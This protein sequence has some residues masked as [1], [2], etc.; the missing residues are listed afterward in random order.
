MPVRRPVEAEVA[1]LRSRPG[2]DLRRAVRRALGRR[3]EIRPQLAFNSDQH[4]RVCCEADVLV[5]VQVIRDP[6]HPSIGIRDFPD[7][8]GSAGR[9]LRRYHQA[10]RIPKPGYASHM[11]PTLRADLPDLS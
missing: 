6:A 3:P 11:K 7:L 4:L 9:L 1:V 8:P 5:V 2:A 10:A